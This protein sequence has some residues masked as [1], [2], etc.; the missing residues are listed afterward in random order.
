MKTSRVAVLALGFTG[1]VA[2]A[3]AGVIAQSRPEPRDELAR[4]RVLRLDGRGG[5]LGVVVQDLDAAG[6]KA[7][8]S[9]GVRIDE[10]DEGSPAA[11]AG[12][13]EGDIVV[14]VDGDRVRSARQF[15]RVI[16]ETPDGGTVKLGIV[17][18]GQRQT[19][20]VTPESR[21]GWFPDGDRISRDIE[22]GLRDLGPR[23]RE[24]GPRLRELEPGLRDFRFEGPLHFD[25]DFDMPRMTGPRRRLGIQ[26][27]SLPQQLA[28]Y[29]GAKDGGVLVSSVRK[30]SPADK[31]GLKAGDVITSI[32]GDRVRDPDDLVDELRDIQ[33]GEVSIG[34]LRDKRETTVKATIEPVRPERV[35]P[36]RPV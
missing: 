10:V 13:R 35:G 1:V 20:D 2:V 18:N 7:A 36:A 33:A 15:S 4:P 24:L 27:G 23:M 34:I 5:Q 28:E 16:Q 26:M 19:V 17:R 31:A 32:N 21:S 25:F 29:F 22:R 6:L 14:D 8:G 11:K 9:P 3:V 30:D 12:L